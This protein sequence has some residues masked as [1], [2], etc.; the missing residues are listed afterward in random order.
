MSLMVSR[1]MHRRVC[2]F[3]E[4]CYGDSNVSL[5]VSR[6]IHRRVF[7]FRWLREPILWPPVTIGVF[8]RETGHVITIYC[9]RS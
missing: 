8:P 6:R 4:T 2:L 9:S 5:G 1:R 7:A 3:L